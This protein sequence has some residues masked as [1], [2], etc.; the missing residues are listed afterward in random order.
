[1]KKKIILLSIILGIVLLIL[2]PSN[3]YA[4]NIFSGKKKLKINVIDRK[5]STYTTINKETTITIRSEEDIYGLYIVYE[6]SSQTG[7]L[8]SNGK[9]LDIGKNN[10]L[11]EYINVNN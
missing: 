10:F 4:S 5:E 8:S 9:S 11:H 7:K 2:I 6:Y 1:M 3:V